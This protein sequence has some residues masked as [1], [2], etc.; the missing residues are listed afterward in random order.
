MN[1]SQK[2]LWFRARHYGWGWTPITWQ[3]WTVLGGMVAIIAIGVSVLSYKTAGLAKNSPQALIYTKD[4]MALVIADVLALI[5]ICYR[6]GEQP[7]WS[8]GDSTKKNLK[9]DESEQ[10]HHE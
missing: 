10:N 9:N 2:K 5:L 3:G 4:F 1:D 8:W 7:H 6:K